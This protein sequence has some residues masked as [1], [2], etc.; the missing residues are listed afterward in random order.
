[1]SIRRRC[2]AGSSGLLPWLPA[3]GPHD[4]TFAPCRDGEG[5][6]G[7]TPNRD[8]RPP[9]TLR[10]VPAASWATTRRQ[11]TSYPLNANWPR[12]VFLKRASFPLVFICRRIA[13]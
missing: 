4:A 13:L 8:T 5:P 1:M 7:R 3:A 11:E 12:S 2:D 6:G 10:A 9:T